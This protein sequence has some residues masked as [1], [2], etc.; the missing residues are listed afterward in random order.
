MIDFSQNQYILATP[1]KCHFFETV[2]QYVETRANGTIPRTRL[3]TAPHPKAYVSDVHILL[4][5]S[6]ASNSGVP[7]LVNSR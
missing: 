7:P 3:V 6:V 2:P 1:Q 4:P 5:F